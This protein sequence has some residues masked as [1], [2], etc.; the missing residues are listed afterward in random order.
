MD[1]RDAVNDNTRK[2]D[3]NVYPNSSSNTRRDLASG[4]TLSLW[5]VLVIERTSV[6]GISNKITEIS[7]GIVRDRNRTKT[8]ITIDY[9]RSAPKRYLVHRYRIP[10]SFSVGIRSLSTTYPTVESVSCDSLIISD[11]I[12]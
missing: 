12:R 10:V 3:F 5:F 7:S 2:R 11:G 9:G 1:P 8:K 4:E 6:R